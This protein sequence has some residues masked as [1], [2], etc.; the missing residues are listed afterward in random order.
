MDW[1]LV[2]IIVHVIGTVLGVGGA[3][4][5]EIFL[6]KGLDLL[7]VERDMVLLALPKFSLL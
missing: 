1:H 5:A 7:V 6:L 2:L 3:T 4:F